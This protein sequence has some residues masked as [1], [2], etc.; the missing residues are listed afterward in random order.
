M[1][2]PARLVT[3]TAAAALT[4][5]ALGLAIPSAHA[6]SLGRP[7][8]TATAECGADGTAGGDAAAFCDSAGTAAGD[9][10]TAD[11][12]ETGDPGPADGTQSLGGLDLAED[13]AAVTEPAWPDSEAPEDEA[14]ADTGDEAG[15]LR[16]PGTGTGTDPGARPEP[17]G[18]TAPGTDP[19]SAKPPV[20]P[21]HRPTASPSP[22][23][24]SGHVGTGVGGSA[25]PD[26][27]QLAAGAGL[28]AAAALSGALLLRRRRT[29][30]P[31]H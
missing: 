31:R 18:G 28:V 3:G 26:T 7:E 25:A 1:R 4:A 6:D 16:Q 12:L 29:D 17:P 23:R 13:P 5:A 24:P 9:L 30:G 19:G 11:E 27:A 10:G 22:S 2:S 14:G 8:L 20:P 21:G 15:T